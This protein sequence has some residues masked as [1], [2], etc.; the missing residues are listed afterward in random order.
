MAF[1]A[2]TVNT[3][4]WGVMGAAA[5]VFIFSLFGSYVTYDFGGDEELFGDISGGVSAWNSY[6]TL[7]VLLLIA[8]GALAAA[9]VFGG[10]VLP[11]IGVGWNLVAAGAA[12]LGTLLLVLRAFT[13]PDGLGLDVG[14]GW[15][16]WVLMV[17]AIAETVFAVMAFR[18]SGEKVP[19]QQQP[20]GPA[21]TPPPSSP[22]PA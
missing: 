4:D 18:T 11:D 3:N 1:D 8:V 14:P 5:G 7:G 6:A 15:S 9:R 20:G 22:P 12:A 21:A 13:Y 10:V 2:K 17:L 19:W 16:G